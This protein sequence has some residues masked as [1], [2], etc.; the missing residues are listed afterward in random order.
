MPT[1]LRTWVAISWPLS[2]ICTTVGVSRASTRRPMCC[3]GA[4]Y[5][6]LPTLT[7]MSG[8][9]LPVDQ[10]ASTNG[11]FG[12]DRNACASTARN[13]AIGAA[14]ASGRQCRCPATSRHQAKACSRICCSEV[15]SRPRQNESRTYGIGRSTRGLSFGLAAR[16]GSISVS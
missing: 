7:W 1:V 12:S 4:E 5:S 13:T 14:P 11:R 3:Q 2:K 9:I 8:P 16:A 15:N 6:V 10:V